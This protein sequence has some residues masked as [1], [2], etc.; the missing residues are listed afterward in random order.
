MCPSQEEMETMIAPLD[1]LIEEG[2]Y[3][4]P[5]HNGCTC[6][7]HKE[8]GVIHMMACCHPSPKEEMD[9][10]TQRLTTAFEALRKSIEE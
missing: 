3:L 8:P 1:D 10:E 9:K 5:A 4:P 6:L 7:C 2:P